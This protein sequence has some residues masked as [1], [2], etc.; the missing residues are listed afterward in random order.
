MTSL[1]PNEDA[2]RASELPPS[3]DANM[4]LGG[5]DG[6]AS[7][8]VYSL[9]QAH[10]LIVAK[11]LDRGSSMAD[12]VEGHRQAIGNL[13]GGIAANVSR[14]NELGFAT[15]LAA[16]ALEHVLFG[17]TRDPAE[18][19]VASFKVTRTHRA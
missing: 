12:I 14:G 18:Q 13:L 16:G 10:A 9:M 8:V 7:R 3:A 1:T 6:V 11:E 15:A 2:A 17:L 5:V 19:E 4:S